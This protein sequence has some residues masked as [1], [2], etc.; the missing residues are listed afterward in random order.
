MVLVRNQQRHQSLRRRDASTSPTPN[1]HSGDRA[2]ACESDPAGKDERALTDIES[3][4]ERPLACL[5][6]RRC[7]AGPSACPRLPVTTSGP[8]AP[9]CSRSP[10]RS[11]PESLT[12]I[13][14][15]GFRRDAGRRLWRRRRVPLRAPPARRHSVRGS[16]CARVCR[17]TGSGRRRPPIVILPA[18]YHRNGWD[19]R[20]RPP[21]GGQQRLLRPG[22][23]VL[24]C[25]GRRA[26]SLGQD[27][28]SV[29]VGIAAHSVRAVPARWFEAIAAYSDKPTI[30]S[31]CARP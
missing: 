7:G 31:P 20:D 26:P 15:A 1:R 29:E 23:R 14:Q 9:R 18:A 19:G 3:D 4:A 10:T 2:R 12:A 11:T 22:R 5:S 28:P 13:A 24:P 8:G 17:G 16:E 30:S 6:T 27:Q 25:P 21:V